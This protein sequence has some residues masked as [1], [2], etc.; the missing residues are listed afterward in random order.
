MIM[1]I[2]EMM[3]LIAAYGNDESNYKHDYN[4]N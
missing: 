4:S 3:L 1:L 2:G